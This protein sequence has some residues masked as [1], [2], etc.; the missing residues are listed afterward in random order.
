DPAKAIAAARAEQKRLIDERMADAKRAA[1]K[2]K[3]ADMAPAMLRQAAR[4][5]GTLVEFPK[6]VETHDTPALAAGRAA[7]RD[8]ATEPVHSAEVIALQRQLMAEAAQPAKVAP[9]RTEETPHQRWRR[10]R[11]MEAALARGDEIP[12][13]QLLWLGGYQSG[14][15]YRGFALTYGVTETKSPAEAG[16]Q[17]AN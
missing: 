11:D 1:R 5:T 10:A 13:E 6:A 7:I 9:L 14:P 17:V 4:E 3:A 8:D 2:I 16:H 15:E 12:S